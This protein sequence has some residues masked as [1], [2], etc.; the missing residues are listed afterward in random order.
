MPIN[1]SDHT[2]DI[3]L[4][5]Q[6]GWESD[7]LEVFSSAWEPWESWKS[8]NKNMKKNTTLWITP[9]KFNID[10]PKKWWLEHV[11][12]T[13]NMAKK[14]VVMWYI[15][16]L[17]FHGW[18]FRPSSWAVKE[19]V[20]TIKGDSRDPQK[21]DP[22]MV[23]FPYHSHIFRDSYGGILMGVVWEWYGK[24]TIRGSHFWGSLKIPLKQ[25]Q[26]NT[27]RETPSKNLPICSMGLIYSPTVYGWF[28]FFLM[29]NVG[30]YTIHGAYGLDLNS[31]EMLQHLH[32]HILVR[33]PR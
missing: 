28:L 27:A 29:V 10:V 15:S 30:K 2:S 4:T 25:L 21:W 22:L 20:K 33:I 1:T 26:Q 24:L 14:M 16:S 32:L 31:T 5:H 23:S 7:D 8:P 17:E 3:P 19:I 11:S 13:S 12:P 18:N 9:Q 6:E